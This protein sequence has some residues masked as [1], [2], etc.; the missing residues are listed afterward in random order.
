MSRVRPHIGLV[1]LLI[2]GVALRVFVMFEYTPA[3]LTNADSGRFLY[4]AHDAER[5]FHDSF[6]PVGYEA[7][8]RVVRLITTR[9]E[10]TIAL[11]HLF[12]ITA[13]LLLYAALRRVGAAWWPALIPAAVLLISGDQLYIQHALL[14]ESPFILLVAAGLYA[15]VRGLISAGREA[16]VWIAIAGAVL[17]AAATFRNVGLVLPPGRLAW[18]SFALPGGCRARLIGAGAAA[19]GALP[20]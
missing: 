14:S 8:L 5:F 16:A 12:G 11:Q 2:A 1:I 10:V 17:A 15:A 18:A 19:A 4:Y 3:A 20:G 9:L 13:A 6:G 7:F